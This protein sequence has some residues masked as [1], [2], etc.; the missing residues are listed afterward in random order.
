[1]EAF[2]RPSGPIGSNQV[3]PRQVSTSG[4]MVTQ[5]RPMNGRPEGLDFNGVFRLDGYA[6]NAVIHR[7]GDP[8]DRAFVVKSGRVRL[9]RVGPDATRDLTL[10]VAPV[11][12]VPIVDMLLGAD[13]LRTRR[14]WLSF[15]TK[16]MF[17]ATR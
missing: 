7:P 13:W 8:A 17:V 16:Q 5:T 10:W 15:A 14:V 4:M 1:M 3:I 12:I 11:H 6:S 2:I 9:L